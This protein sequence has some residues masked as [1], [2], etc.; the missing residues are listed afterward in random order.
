[1][2]ERRNDTHEAL[3]KILVYYF[4]ESDTGLYSGIVCLVKKGVSRT[5]R[6]W[7]G[8]DCAFLIGDRHSMT[9]MQDTDEGSLS[10]EFDRLWQPYVKP[11]SLSAWPRWIEPL[12]I[13]AGK[14]ILASVGFTESAGKVLVKAGRFSLGTKSRWVRTKLFMQLCRFVKGQDVTEM[15]LSTDPEELSDFLAIRSMNGEVSRV[16]AAPPSYLLGKLCQGHVGQIEFTGVVD[17][18]LEGPIVIRSECGT[19]VSLILSPDAVK[20]AWPR[21]GEEPPPDGEEPDEGFHME[22]KLLKHYEPV[23]IEGEPPGTQRKLIEGP[24]E[25]DDDEG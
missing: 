25:G 17:G 19:M 21:K 11:G 6:E 4:K 3:R 22:A 15:R 8:M 23:L 18:Q 2:K 13:A 24:K 14:D 20:K 9:F 12:K 1:M 10:L 7:L 16:E 5:V